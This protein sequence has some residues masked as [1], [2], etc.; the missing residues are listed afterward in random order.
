MVASHTG[1]QMPA[2]DVASKPVPAATAVAPTFPTATQLSND[3]TQQGLQAMP[4]AAVGFEGAK[5]H[6]RPALV[7]ALL[8]A[9]VAGFGVYQQGWQAWVSDPNV[10]FYAPIVGAVLALMFLWAAARRRTVGVWAVGDQLRI[11][12]GL[13]V[14]RLRELDLS[15]VDDI[16]VR[17]S[18]LGNSGRVIVRTKDGKRFVAKGLENPDDAATFLPLFLA[19]CRARNTV[20]VSHEEERR[21]RVAA[22]TPHVVAIAPSSKTSQNAS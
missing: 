15:E 13:P 11:A 4:L 5:A 17:R 6:Y 8:L 21:I 14:L 22:T 20:R 3:N 16:A 19:A 12:S 1:Q 7:A 2:Q 9:V 10:R 18:F